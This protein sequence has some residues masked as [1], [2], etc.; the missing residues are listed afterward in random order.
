MIAHDDEASMVY[1]DGV[2]IGGTM[3]RL[4]TSPIVHYSI[5]DDWTLESDIVYQDSINTILTDSAELIKYHLS[6]TVHIADDKTIEQAHQ[7]QSKGE[8]LQINRDPGAIMFTGTD[9]KVNYAQWAGIPDGVMDLLDRHVEH[10][11]VSRGVNLFLNKGLTAE[12]GT[13]KKEARRILFNL[14]E[15][16]RDVV[17]LLFSNVASVH[18]GIYRQ[19]REDVKVIFPPMQETSA[20]EKA[21]LEQMHYAVHNNVELYMRRVGGFTEDEIAIAKSNDTSILI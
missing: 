20:S 7:Q 14:A 12:S 18:S 16:R 4:G 13:A 21:E 2:Y 8:K 9:G 3:H 19:N 17:K 10:F 15:D 1:A 5:G 11:C 6:P